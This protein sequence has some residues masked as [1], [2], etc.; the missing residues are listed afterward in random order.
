MTYIE[1]LRVPGG[2]KTVDDDQ[3]ELRQVDKCDAD[4]T[5]RYLRGLMGD[6]VYED[7]DND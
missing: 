4:S 2:A 6:D 5:E 1:H 7:W 3:R